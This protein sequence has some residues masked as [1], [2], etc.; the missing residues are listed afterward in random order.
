[1]ADPHKAH[2]LHEQVRANVVMA[3]L[4]LMTGTPA[5]GV[6]RADTAFRVEASKG[7]LALLEVATAVQTEVSL[8]IYSSDPLLAEAAKIIEKHIV[9]RG[10]FE[11]QE[12]AI[13]ETDQILHQWISMISGRGEEMN[14]IA[15]WI[16]R[17]GEISLVDLAERLGIQT[18]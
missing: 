4:A 9:A 11:R 15:E 12:K 13:V 7:Y 1:M 8:S 2:T 14:E 6:V 10:E 16:Y 17:N 5:N 3:T 18:S